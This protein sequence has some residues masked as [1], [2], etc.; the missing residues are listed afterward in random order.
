MDWN[1]LKQKITPYIEKAT[2]YLDTARA[3]GQKAVVFAED[4]LQTTPLFIKSQAEYDALLINKR[5]IIIAY[6]E[7]DISAS[8]VRQFSPLWIT[9][10][11]L[12]NATLRFISLSDSSDLCS[13]LGLL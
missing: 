3:Y 11:F 4:Q 5:T 6:D 9:R 10:A 1:S 13:V 8:Q 12:D 7:R 2:P